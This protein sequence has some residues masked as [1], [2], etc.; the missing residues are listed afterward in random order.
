MPRGHLKTNEIERGDLKLRAIYVEKVDQQQGTRTD[1]DCIDE[2]GKDFESLVVLIQ[3]AYG[4]P[5]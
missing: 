4:Q 3:V 1:W 2:T 5:K